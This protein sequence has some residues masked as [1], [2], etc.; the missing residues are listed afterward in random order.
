MRMTN[1][2]LELLQNELSGCSNYLEFGSGNSIV[3]AASTMNIEE[4]TV[5]ESDSLFWKRLILSNPV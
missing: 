5:V 4:I 3:L 2:E 1:K